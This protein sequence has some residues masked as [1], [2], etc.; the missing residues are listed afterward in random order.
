[1]N[2]KLRAMARILEFAGTTTANVATVPVPLGGK[3]PKTPNKPGEITV[4]L[5]ICPSC[6][7]ETEKWRSV[8]RHCGKPVT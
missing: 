3:P 5:T 4:D 1:M 2:K 8:C 6:G 7:K